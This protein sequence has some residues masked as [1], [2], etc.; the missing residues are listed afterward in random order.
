[1]TKDNKWEDDCFIC[2]VCDTSFCSPLYDISKQFAR[3]IF[4][5]EPRPSEIDIIGSKT[6]VTFCSPGCRDRHR[7]QLLQQEKIRAAFPGIGPIEICSR[8]NGPVVMTS[9][10]LAYVEMD[11]E[12]DRARKI[13]GT[14]VNYVRVLAVVCQNC[15]PIPRYIEVSM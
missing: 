6:I 8:C 7:D 12:H 15:E 4:Y 14:E 5:E 2:D 9:F 3:T 11:T 10:H 13:F 1:M